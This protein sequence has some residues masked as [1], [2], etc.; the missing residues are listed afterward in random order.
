MNPNYQEFKF[1]QIRSVQWESMFKPHAP[2][3]AID[4]VS[5][6]LV[7]RPQRR[8]LAIESCSHPFYNDIRNPASVMPDASGSAL[9]ATLFEFTQEELSLQPSMLA[10]LTPAHVPPCVK[11]SNEPLDDTD[12]HQTDDL[13]IK[14]AVAQGKTGW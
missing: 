6:L 13:E 1:P 5:R 8:Y 7:Y 10:V 2:P 11:V 14:A 3:E 12:A 4:L 9:P